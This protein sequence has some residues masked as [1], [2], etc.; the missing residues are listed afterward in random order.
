MHPWH[1]GASTFPCAVSVQINLVYCRV[2]IV[3][4]V[5]HVDSDR[6]GVNP[7]Q[8]KFSRHNHAIERY[9]ANLDCSLFAKQVIIT[10]NVILCLRCNQIMHTMTAHCNVHT[11]YMYIISIIST[12]HYINDVILKGGSSF[13][14]FLSH[15]ATLSNLSVYW[16]HLQAHTIFTWDLLILAT[17][18]S[19]LS[20]EPSFL[21]LAIRVCVLHDPSMSMNND[22]FCEVQLRLSLLEI[23]Y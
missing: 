14:P 2:N 4:T 7:L 11:P 5:W 15:C 1:V 9:L 23:P 3:H 22:S 18:G 17:G 10:M 16:G 12:L 8:N 21:F 6:K 19:S 13:T 20:I